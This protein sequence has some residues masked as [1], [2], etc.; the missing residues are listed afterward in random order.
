[1]KK[2]LHSLLVGSLIATSFAHAKNENDG[3]EKPIR[4]EVGDF[5]WRANKAVCNGIA[6]VKDNIDLTVEMF[7]NRNLIQKNVSEDNDFVTIEIKAAGIKSNALVES[8]FRGEKEK[9]EKK[10]IIISIHSDNGPIKAIIDPAQRILN[11]IFEKTQESEKEANSTSGRHF[12]GGHIPFKF[13]EKLFKY[14]DASKQPTIEQDEGKVVILFPKK[15]EF[16]IHPPEVIK[17]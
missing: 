15:E 8:A 1:M 12:S 3:F 7:N 13:K 11:I 4:V 5:F 14:I 16:R 6:I 10:E 2:N 9:Q 17:K